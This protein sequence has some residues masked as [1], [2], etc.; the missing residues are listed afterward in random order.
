MHIKAIQK[1]FFL[2]K[3]IPIDD[4]RISLVHSLIDFP[5]AFLAYRLAKKLNCPFIFTGHGTFSVAP[6]SKF[7]DRQIMMK[8]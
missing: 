4:K 5:Y 3:K 2:W 6:F 7:P 8:L 1:I